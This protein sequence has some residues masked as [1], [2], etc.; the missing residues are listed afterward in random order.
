MS[1]ASALAPAALLSLSE[2]RNCKLIHTCEHGHDHCA[3]TRL[4]PCADEAAALV[5]GEVYAADTPI[6]QQPET[7]HQVVKRIAKKHSTKP[8]L[9]LF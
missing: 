5:A 3:L 1:K 6:P 7:A 2:A 8:Q 4:G 9:M